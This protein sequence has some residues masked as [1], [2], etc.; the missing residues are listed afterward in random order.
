MQK[1]VDKVMQ[2][3]MAR[4][5]Q[6]TYNFTIRLNYNITPD[7]SIQYYGSPFISAGSY[8]S[9]KRASDAAARNLEDRYHAFS[10]TEIAYDD[11]SGRY[12]VNEGNANYSFNNPDFCFREFR[13]NLV[14]RWEYKP[15]SIFYL[16]WENNRRSRDNTYLPSLDHNFNDLFSTEPTNVIMLKLCYWF[17]I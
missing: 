7:V 8:S 6:Q 11:L 5:N 1:E 17:G 12:L 2:Y 9:F 13:S 4:I 16:V 15:G 10:D 14:A 3:I